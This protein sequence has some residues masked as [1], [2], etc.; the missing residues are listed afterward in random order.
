[1]SLW[2]R[3]LFAPS[4][5]DPPVSPQ[6]YSSH[7]VRSDILGHVTR[8]ECEEAQVDGEPQQVQGVGVHDAPDEGDATVA[9]QRRRGEHPRQEQEEGHAKRGEELRHLDADKAYAHTLRGLR[10]VEY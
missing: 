2:H 5:G 9:G 6:P 3:S 4:P 10:R 1:M 8:T 7:T